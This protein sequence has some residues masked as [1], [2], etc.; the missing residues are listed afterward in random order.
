MSPH[1]SRF[2]RDF[3]TQQAQLT[4]GDK[5]LQAVKTLPKSD[6]RETLRPDGWHRASNG[7]QN[8]SAMIRSSA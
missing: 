3:R 5:M 1:G 2:S 8:I 6:I 4:I 7:Q